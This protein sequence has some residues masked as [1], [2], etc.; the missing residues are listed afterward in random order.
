LSNP[1]NIGHDT[2]QNSSHDNLAKAAENTFVLT[3]DCEDARKLAS[4]VAC[5]GEHVSRWT[6]T[7][8]FGLKSLPIEENPVQT[9]V[10][11]M[12]E[13]TPMLD[14]DLDLSTSV[15]G[16]IWDEKRNADADQTESKVI[17]HEVAEVL[18]CQFSYG[19]SAQLPVSPVAS[20]RRDCSLSRFRG[21]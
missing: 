14:G 4:V 21:K 9:P 10:E 20:G 8:T 12:R 18:W 1:S 6:L 19:A 15:D 16:N 11:A 5:W 3:E 2:R 17:V 13:A 7:A